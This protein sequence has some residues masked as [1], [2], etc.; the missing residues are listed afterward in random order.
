ME[1]EELRYKKNY[2]SVMANKIIRGK[3]KMT[4]YEAKLIR[5][6]ISQ[7]KR[8]DENFRMYQT[9]IKNLAEI[10]GTDRK[11][12]QRE[13]RNVCKNL[14]KQI[15]EI[16]ND[17]DWEILH[18]LSYAKYDSKKGLIMLMLSQEIS[19]YVLALKEKFTRYQTKNILTMQSFY[20]IRLYELL[21][22]RI[23][24]DKKKEM[25]YQFKVTELRVILQCESRFKQVGEFK[26]FVLDIAIKEISEETEYS[27]TYNCRKTGRIITDILFLIQ[28]KKQ[29]Q[30]QQEVEL[31]IDDLVDQ[32]R[33]IIKEELTT[34]EYKAILAAAQNDI[35]LI[36]AKYNIAKKQGN[37]DNL[38]GWL[39][40]AIETDYSEPI[41]KKSQSKNKFNDFPQRQ[42]SE[43]ELEELERR[44]LLKDLE[45]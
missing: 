39:I 17:G 14:M 1:E 23:G 45:I 21:Q 38:V 40:K 15:V 36:I 42:Y 4:I 24:M 34:K 41:S 12:I 26:R 3:Q 37:I 11:N 9:D 2:Y 44:L 18:W 32:L 13:I 27:C 16:E 25:V 30:K 22:M 33:K 29:T 43:E 5:V 28:E 20:A 7:I 10:L 31:D 6:L 19:P 35:N 8:D